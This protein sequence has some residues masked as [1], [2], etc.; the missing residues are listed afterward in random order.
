MA[1]NGHWTPLSSTGLLIRG[2]PLHT[3]ST[4][5]PNCPWRLSRGLVGPTGVYTRCS[6]MMFMTTN[7]TWYLVFCGTPRIR[8]I[9]RQSFPASRGVSCHA[10]RTRRI[11]T[12]RS[13]SNHQRLL[14]RVQTHSSGHE[15]NTLYTATEASLRHLVGGKQSG[16]G[17]GAR[18]NRPKQVTDER[19]GILQIEPSTTFQFFVNQA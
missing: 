1:C 8:N 15:R 18:K 9:R 2:S 17:I 4:T 11:Q 5:E 14:M 12:P 10:H 3:C 7:H 16:R 19:H 6:S 13:C